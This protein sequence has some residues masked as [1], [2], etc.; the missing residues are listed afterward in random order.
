MVLSIIYPMAFGEEP[1]LS[2]YEERHGFEAV[3]FR[4]FSSGISSHQ[5]QGAKVTSSGA[6]H[7]VI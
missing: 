2:C 3:P 6:G 7:P 5:E 1:S 4:Q